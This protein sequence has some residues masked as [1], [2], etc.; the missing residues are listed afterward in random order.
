MKRRELEKALLVLETTPLLL[1][2]ID[3]VPPAL[4]ARV[5]VEGVSVRDRAWALAVLEKDLWNRSIR[6]ILS[7]DMPRLTEVSEHEVLERASRMD[8]D[9]REA[10]RVFGVFRGQNVRLL[11]QAAGRQWDRQGFFDPERPMYLREVPASMARSDE[12][13]QTRLL[14]VF[15]AEDL[16]RDAEA[17]VLAGF[18]A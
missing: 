11:R 6:L 4:T 9:H 13:Q 17:P 16:P 2:R 7:E 18:C 8:G 1:R 10:L 14:R 15:P 12:R 3:A 5:R